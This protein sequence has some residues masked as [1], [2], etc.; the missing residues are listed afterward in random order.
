MNLVET[1][2]YSK[3]CSWRN[4]FCENE[5]SMVLRVDI[6]INL[7]SDLRFDNRVV[8]ITGAGR[9]IGKEY[10]L[11]FASKGAKVL[12]N[13]SGCDIDGRNA[14]KQFA[15]QVVFIPKAGC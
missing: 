9:G 8:I 6:K 7:M 12:V 13:D 5:E 1:E 2:F 4:K 11:F 10:A 14:N 15:D 3:S